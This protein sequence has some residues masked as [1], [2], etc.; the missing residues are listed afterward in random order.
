MAAD[1]LNEFLSISFTHHIEIISK[2]KDLQER[3]FYIHQSFVNR[4]D[5]YKL[6]DMLKSDLFQHQGNL[7]NNFST[8]MQN[9]RNALQ[10]IGMFKDEYLLDFINVEELGVRDQEDIDERV[11]ENAIVHNVKNFIM[12]FGRDF[13]FVGNQYHLEKFGH[14]D[15]WVN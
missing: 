15:I 9:T 3:L 11:V 7:P 2:S 8:T 4:W 6:R 5:K 14:D 12:T 10:A 1:M 13:A